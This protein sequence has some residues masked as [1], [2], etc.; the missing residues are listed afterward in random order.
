MWA[1]PA[2]EEALNEAAKVPSRRSAIPYPEGRGVAD[3]FPPSAARR[4]A[5]LERSRA[6]HGADA[7]PTHSHSEAEPDSHS[8]TEPDSYSE[9][10]P[11]SYSETEPDSYSETKPDS[12]SEAEPDSHASAA[13]DSAAAVRAVAE[14]HADVREPALPRGVERDARRTARG[15]LLRLAAGL[16]QILLY[17][18]DPKWNQ[19]IAASLSTD[20]RG[21]VIANGGGVPGYWNFTGGLRLHFQQY[22]RHGLED[23]RSRCSRNTRPSARTA[24][25]PI[26]PRAP[27]TAARSPTA[28]R[29]DSTRWRSASRRRPTTTSW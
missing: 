4:P 13:H 29:R 14:R 18:R 22:G 27:A 2:H 17:T 5:E 12:H 19:C 1:K 15:H 8:E 21:W 23:A 20:D 3:A 26:G 7:L 25:Q 9:A 28:S 6:K 11:Y 16:P 24:R 10:E